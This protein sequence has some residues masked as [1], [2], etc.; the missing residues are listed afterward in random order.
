MTP[1]LLAVGCVLIPLLLAATGAVVL[2][3]ARC[4][5]GREWA[6][7]LMGSAVWCLA[8]TFS[9]ITRTNPWIWCLALLAVAGGAGV[10]FRRSLSLRTPELRTFYLVYFFTLG[11]LCVLPFP[12]MWLMGGDWMQHYGAAAAV[13]D[14]MFGVGQIASCPSFAAGAIVC[15]PFHPSLAALEIYVAATTAASLLVLLQGA[16]SPA[17]LARRRWAIGCVCLSAFY[18]VHLQNLWPKWL[19]AGFFVAAILEA[20][21]HRTRGDL[22]S[23]LLAIFWFGIS[24]AVHASSLLLTPFLVVALG[25]P[26]I[27]AL[28]RQRIVWAAGSALLLLT[29]GGWQVWTLAIYGMKQGAVQLPIVMGND[30]RTIPARMAYNLADLLVGLLPPDFRN[31]WSGAG[32]HS[33]LEET[34]YTAIAL[35]SWMAATLLTIF[36]PMLW[37]LRD[38]VRLWW[39]SAV[40][41]GES[42]PW[43]GALVL[44]LLLN[45]VVISAPPRYGAAQIGFAPVCLLGLMLLFTRVFAHAPAVRL[46]RLARWHL[47]T[48]LL[49]YALLSLGVLLALHS[50]HGNREAVVE[51]L[52]V[53]D[54]DWWAVR[55]LRLEV[56]AAEFFPVG[57]VVFGLGCL[58][59]W[60]GALSAAGQNVR[61][62][63]TWK[64]EG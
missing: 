46:A 9:I 63:R 3:V 43:S 40:R 27:R 30:G 39:R 15:L 28:A 42:R 21:R 11:V 17:E 52:A 4:A 25:W 20:L 48:G 1:L 38:E 51:S 2:R 7:P 35:S 47:F 61:T 41:S 13:W 22:A 6:A 23:A 53:S 59:L 45:C 8:G 18:L 44:S 34:H 56:L 26:A 60:A 24:I 19:A 31:R 57:I 29:C 10:F 32:L 12:G 36:G 64:D 55:H 16:R 58:A 14:R 33:V 49:P 50:P 5:S 37:L 54:S 62:R